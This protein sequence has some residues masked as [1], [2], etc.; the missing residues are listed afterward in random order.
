MKREKKKKKKQGRQAGKTEELFLFREKKKRT[1]T[2]F[3]SKSFFHL[4]LLTRV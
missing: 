1:K 4:G 3:L 2:L